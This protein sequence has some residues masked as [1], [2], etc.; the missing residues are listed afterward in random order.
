M[1]DKIRRLIELSA[2]EFEHIDMQLIAHLDGTRCMLKAWGARDALQQAG[3]FHQAYS[4][5]ITKDKRFINQS[6]RQLIADVIGADSELIVYHY[7]ACDREIF[8]NSLLVQEKPDY[9]DR[10]LHRSVQLE[11][12]LLND[13]CELFVA[14]ELELALNAPQTYLLQDLNF[15]TF[16]VKLQPYLSRGANNKVK[17]L[18]A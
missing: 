1:L 14:T 4:K 11:V 8:F 12:Q 7:C 9:V 2:G 5:G 6:Q 16:L 10:F 17:Q 3:L 13:L 15:R 18:L